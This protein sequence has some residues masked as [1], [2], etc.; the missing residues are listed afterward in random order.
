MSS[1]GSF[2]NTG[3]C[4][5]LTPWR[6]IL[7]V[8]R[9]ARVALAIIAFGFAAGCG[10]GHHS[11]IKSH[12]PKS[13]RSRASFPTAARVA[14]ASDG[15]LSIFA[16]R[17]GVNR[18]SIPDGATATS[19]GVL[20][21]F[22]PGRCRTTVRVAPTQEPALIVTFTESWPRCVQGY[23]PGAGAV[24][25]HHTW[26]IMVSLPFGRTRQPSVVNAKTGSTGAL[27]PQ[28]YQ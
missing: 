25:R 26:H 9:S 4:D 7:G 6:R 18:C 27:P 24:L 21:R 5:G 15:L 20:K 22:I 23:C 16:P 13:D 3:P 11:D 28:D 10:S 19:T 2:L 1:Q 17:P 12:P 14:K 8:M